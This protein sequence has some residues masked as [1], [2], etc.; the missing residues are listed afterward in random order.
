MENK[1]PALI[2]FLEEVAATQW[3][4]KQT[5]TGTI[6]IQQ[7]V[8]NEL[9]RKGMEALAKDLIEL[10]GSYSDIVETADGITLVEQL[11]GDDLIAEPTFNWEIDCTIK[12]VNYDAFA[13][14]DIYAE[15]KEKKDRE[16]SAK[17]AEKQLK[18][19]QLARRRAARE[20]EA[21]R[22][23]EGTREVVKIPGFSRVTE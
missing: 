20:A 22:L 23:V 8:R 16:R 14:A 4:F 15:A 13:E 5:S 17:Q 19:D 7:T 18:E 2:E 6:T 1:K 12:A 3:P 21:R 11:I 9:R 10:Y